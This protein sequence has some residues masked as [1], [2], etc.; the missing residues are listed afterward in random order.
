MAAVGLLGM[1]VVY[2]VNAALKDLVGVPRLVSYAVA[3]EASILHNFALNDR[4]TFRG[5]GRGKPLL[6]RLLDY[7]YSVAVGALTN[8]SAYQALTHLG[9]PDPLAIVVGVALGYAA[10]YL[11]A[12]H[13]VWRVES[14]YSQKNPAVS[15][16]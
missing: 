2:A 14:L 12:E 3:I 15:R 1:L 5:R 8:Y 10:N 6:R 4:W 9:L 13:H 7:H 11:L 16:G